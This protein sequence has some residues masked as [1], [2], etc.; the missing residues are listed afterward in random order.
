MP[1]EETMRKGDTSKPGQ[2]PREKRRDERLAREKAAA[3]A[4]EAFRRTKHE[5][6]PPE[7]LG[8]PPAPKPRERGRTLP[9]GRMDTD[10][11]AGYAGYA[12]D[13]L[14]KWR[15]VGGGPE[16]IEVN[17]RIWYYR[18]AVD[19]WLARKAAEAAAR[20]QAAE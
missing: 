10:A 7:A 1:T 20:R 5:G 13:T 15:S 4:M 9:D 6:Q 2:T 8:P 12:V 11:T 19:A 17:R 3:E 16:F 14:A 18:H